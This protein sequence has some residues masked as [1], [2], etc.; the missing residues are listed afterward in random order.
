M[1]IIIII[2]FFN[3]D[4]F[5]DAAA[6]DASEDDDDNEA[7]KAPGTAP[8]TTRAPHIPSAFYFSSTAR[9]PQSHLDS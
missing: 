3:Y 7:K 6:D 5:N 9:R 1:I 2:M 8:V 4:N